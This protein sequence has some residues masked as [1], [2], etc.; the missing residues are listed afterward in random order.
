MSTV[1]IFIVVFGAVLCTAQAAPSECNPGPVSIPFLTKHGEGWDVSFAKQA[2]AIRNGPYILSDGKD[3]GFQYVE[4]EPKKQVITLPHIEVNP[5][6]HTGIIRDWHLIPKQVI[7]FQKNGRVFA[8][9]VWV[10]MVA[11]PGPD[12]Q[13]I[14]SNT[15]VIFYDMHGDGVFDTVRLGSGIETPTVPDWVKTIIGKSTD[16]VDR[17]TGDLRLSI[18]LVATPKP[19]H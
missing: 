15:H 4:Y 2:N 16:T 5:Y 13:V 14:G 9:R 11:G 8:Y 3:A 17:A 6:N 18:P 10:Q 7:G 12:S 1:T 19:S